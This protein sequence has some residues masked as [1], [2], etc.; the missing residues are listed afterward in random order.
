MLIIFYST[1][2]R[3]SERGK[4]I[5]SFVICILPIAQLCCWS[6]CS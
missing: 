4:S 3:D 1:A 2:F 5:F 6:F